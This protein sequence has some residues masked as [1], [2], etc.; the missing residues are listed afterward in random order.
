[1]FVFLVGVLLLAGTKVDDPPTLFA[2]V[3]VRSITPRVS[4]AD[5]P[6][7]LA[8]FG[9][10]RVAR[11]ID[12]DLTARALV[13]SQGS[14]TVALVA[15]DLIGLLAGE[16]QA[17]RCALAERC[18]GEGPLELFVAA[19]HTHAG[20]DT[21]GLWG[22]R[23]WLS[24]ASRGYLRHVREAIVECVVEARRRLQPS[25]LHAGTVDVSD[26]IRDTRPPQVIHGE[27]TV[28]AVEST[29]GAAIA[30][31]VNLSN[32]PEVLSARNPV[33]SA[34][35]PYYLR[36]KIEAERGGVALYLSGAVGG[37]M[38]PR[39]VEVIDPIT[40]E[41]APRGSLRACELYGE[42]LGA[43]ALGAL[44]SGRQLGAPRVRSATHAIRIPLENGRFRLARWLGVVERDLVDGEIASEVGLVDL[45]ELQMV[46]VPGELYPELWVGGVQHP[47]G[48][49]LDEV[50]ALA[51][52]RETV[53]GPFRMILGL[54]N[55]ELG[56]LIPPGQWDRGAP[57]TYD[58]DEAPYGEVNSVGPLAAERVVRGVEALVASLSKRRD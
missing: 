10:D 12:G 41:R 13:L 34:D 16:V 39:R 33:L 47:E 6:V 21:M 25:V 57:Y 55:D 24:G 23:P 43:K 52:L 42:E 40:K 5:P 44:R 28:L 49:D 31:V 14:E 4:P 36:R 19:T 2:G 50:P 8:G 35:F 45:G 1:M 26:R 46:A 54:C 58:Q 11:A 51:P 48:A 22:R 27:M 56:Y 3:A 9:H 15:V 30:T 7:Y 20:P 17:V 37:L 32:H 38:T 53:A 18:A 29:E